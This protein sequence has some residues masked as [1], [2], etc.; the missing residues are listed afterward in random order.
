MTAHKQT[1]YCKDCSHKFTPSLI[2]KSK[3]TPELV[4]LTLDLYFSGTSLRKISR[5]VTDHT[6]IHLGA[7]TV[8]DWIQKFVPLISSTVSR[9]TPQTSETWHVDEVFVPMKDGQ[10]VKGKETKVAFLWNVMDRKTRFLLCSKLSQYRDV[11]GANSAFM[12]AKWNSHG[13]TP[14]N[15]ITD[16][17]RAYPESVQKSF[18][19]AK[20]VRGVGIRSRRS[21]NR[22]ERCNGTVRERTKVQRGWKSMESQI[23]EGQRLHYNFVKPHMALEKQT[24]AQRSGIAI[25]NSWSEL[26]KLALTNQDRTTEEN[27]Q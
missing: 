17:W 8:Y 26:L 15:V 3:F 16:A 27:N 23:A 18:P 24:P 12:E 25:Q 1:Y 19:N 7:T 6:G 10:N 11:K 4:S 13:I 20:H 21:N 2:K 22:I 9:F 14:E 5:I